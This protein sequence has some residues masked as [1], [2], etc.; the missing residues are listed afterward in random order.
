MS[1]NTPESTDFTYACSICDSEYKAEIL[2]RTHMSWNDDSEHNWCNGFMPEAEVKVIDEMGEFVRKEKGN[3]R[4]TQNINLNDL[5]DNISEIDKH[6]IMKAVDSRD[7]DTYQEFVERVNA[8][9]R[10]N[11]IEKRSYGE[12]RRKPR[13]SARG[14]MSRENKLR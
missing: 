3:G 8:S 7:V 2:A 10:S 14:R 5:P 11:G 9:L 12:S 6:I 1:P 13:A 4:F